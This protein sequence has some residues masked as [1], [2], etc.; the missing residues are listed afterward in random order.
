M[1]RLSVEINAH[2][3]RISETN[4]SQNSVYEHTFSDL[5]DHRYIEQLDAL[6]EDSGLKNRSFD[7]TALS[8]SGF[9]T[10]LVPSNVF[11]DG[12]AQR[13]FELCFGTQVA[14]D[15]ISFD[16]LQ[17]Q[18]IVNIYELPVWIK[19]YFASRFPRIVMRHEGSHLIQQLLSS[20]ISKLEVIVTVHKGYF[21]LCI[22]KEDSLIYYSSFD[23]QEVD[24]ILYHVMFT[25]Q[26]K[27]LYHE[28]GSLQLFN[29]PGIPAEMLEELNE[30]LS[31]IAEIKSL[32]ISLNS[33]LVLNS[34]EQCV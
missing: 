28:E 23:F 16:R 19:S 9:R 30:R 34:L 17:E 1:S 4:D 25:L 10:T 14:E 7:T 29:A 2:H 6:L 27:E 15:A 32:A 21:L 22:G 13:F 20:K 3:V 8:W 12:S 24:D 33:G 18:G 11:E 31:K 5:Q 26:Q